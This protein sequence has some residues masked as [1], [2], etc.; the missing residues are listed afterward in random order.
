MKKNHTPAFTLIELL[1]VVAVIA[2]LTA[3]VIAMIP[4]MRNTAQTSQCAS[5]MRQLGNLMFLYAA[6]NGGRLPAVRP[7][8]TAGR[9][10]R[11]WRR[12]LLPY[13]G[14]PSA[15]DAIYHSKLVC[16]GV[17]AEIVAV[18]G[19]PDICSFGVNIYLSEPENSRRDFGVLLNSLQHPDRILMAT[20][21]FLQSAGTP[22]PNIQQSDFRNANYSRYWNRHNGAQNVL[23]CDGR[24]ELFEQIERIGSPPYNPG[25]EKDIWTP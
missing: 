9:T 14:L 4:N 13:M 2:I 16:P 21:S 24:V 18:G 12:A 1:A 17:Y 11:Y 23:Y 19:Q 7:D 3:I 8:N 15:G 25:S 5:N 20:E 10:D 22:A 6:D